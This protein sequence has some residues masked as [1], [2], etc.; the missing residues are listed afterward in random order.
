[1]GTTYTPTF[2]VELDGCEARAWNSKRH[3]RP[4]DDNLARYVRI[5]NESYLP[6]GCNEHLNSAPHWSARLI[7]QSNGQVVA[8]WTATT[9][10]TVVTENA[11]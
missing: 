1:M 9:T 8:E 7:R 5:T 10:F 6:G 3:G 2:R 4:T 11:A